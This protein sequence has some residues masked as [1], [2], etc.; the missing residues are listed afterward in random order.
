MKEGGNKG[1]GGRKGG[2]EGGRE[3]TV[4]NC[5]KS[6]K[7]GRKDGRMRRHVCQNCPPHYIPWTSIPSTIWLS[8]N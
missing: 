4:L 6:H 3:A 1:E 8:C 7:E 2:K 5:T